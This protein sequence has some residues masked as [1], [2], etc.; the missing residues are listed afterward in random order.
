MNT[1]TWVAENAIPY[2]KSG[3]YK[4]LHFPSQER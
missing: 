4:Q 2:D 3:K 1:P